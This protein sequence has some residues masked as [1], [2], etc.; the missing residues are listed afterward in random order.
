MRINRSMAAAAATLLTGAPL[1][2]IAGA[3]STASAACAPGVVVTP[4]VTVKK[5]P[6]LS[7]STTVRKV[8]GKRFVAATVV[9]AKQGSAT[10][11]VTQTV[12]PDGAAA[13]A[14]S[15][16]QSVSA[17]GTVTRTVSGSSSSK[18][19]ARR[20]AKAK[21]AKVI[22]RIRKVAKTRR[23]MAAAKSRAL[24]VT[25]PVAVQRAHDALYASTVFWLT[26]GA[27][28]RVFASASRPTGA[29]TLAQQP[30]G[31]LVLSAPAAFDPFSYPGSTPCLRRAPAW[32][33]AFI[34]SASS[35][36]APVLA[37]AADAGDKA[38]LTG[39]GPVR[40]A[41]GDVQGGEHSGSPWFY[42]FDGSAG[43]GVVESSG[44]QQMMNGHVGVF[45]GDALCFIFNQAAP[46]GTTATFSGVQV[47]RTFTSTEVAASVTGGVA[48]EVR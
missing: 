36:A 23:G 16:T 30:N 18:A 20:A 29:P 45:A 6:Q 31:A 15:T 17:M 7:T 9:T 33:T 4:H 10:V 11:T 8:K 14:A 32:P 2:V 19:S 48:V 40:Y 13:A 25:R 27:D 28:E 43:S 35:T 38:V 34:A 26:V 1:T 39:F 44:F 46:A 12:C 42:S 21:A 22:A 47:G 5:R 41:D 37:A 3:T 24:A